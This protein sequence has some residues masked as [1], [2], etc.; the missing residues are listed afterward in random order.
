DAAHR[1]RRQYTVDRQQDFPRAD[2]QCGNYA[3]RRHHWDQSWPVRRP[4]RL[5]GVGGCEL[6]GDL[7]QFWRWRPGPG[8]DLCLPDRLLTGRRILMSTPKKDN[9]PAS[10]DRAELRQHI[11]EMVF[12]TAQARNLNADQVVDEVTKYYNVIVG[13]SA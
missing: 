4:V 5:V 6:R 1:D 9:S 2:Q 8:R 7:R 12:A 3:H 11:W 10:T 13:P